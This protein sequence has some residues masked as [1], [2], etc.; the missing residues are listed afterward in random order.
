MIAWD[1]VLMQFALSVTCSVCGWYFVIKVLQ[2]K[3]RTSAVLAYHL[4]FL[5]IGIAACLFTRD[6]PIKYSA[7]FFFFV[8]LG[9]PP[10]AAMI[11]RGKSKEIQFVE[12]ETKR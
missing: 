7:A 9:L 10:L 4:S 1:I 2:T 3:T 6:F 5:I 8:T 12:G 11:F